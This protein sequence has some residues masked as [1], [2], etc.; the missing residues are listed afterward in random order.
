MAAITFTYGTMNSGKSARL[1]QMV[2][3]LRNSK[4]RY[5]VLSPRGGDVTS[6]AFPNFKHRATAFEYIFTGYALKEDVDVILVDEAQFLTADHVS[7]LYT[8]AK[9][10][11]IEVY[12]FGLRNDTNGLPFEG[13]SNLFSVADHLIKLTA[14]C[15]HCG[16]PAD[17][18]GL[19]VG[20]VKPKGKED[21]VSLCH[22]CF[23]KEIK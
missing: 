23:V 21:Y 11:D 22:S 17:M 19:D 14:F 2:H 4:R 15:D 20:V 13:S 6:R 5:T 3:N 8:Y 16:K 18:H 12:A 9:L 7:N 1:L 10:Y